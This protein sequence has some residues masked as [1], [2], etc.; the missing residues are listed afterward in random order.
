MV[1]GD[2]LGKRLDLGFYAMR[3]AGFVRTGAGVVTGSGHNTKFVGL[4]MGKINGKE[5]EKR[6][7]AEGVPS[8]TYA[9]CRCR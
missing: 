1:C 3:D 2:H 5:L 8:L 9:T 7:V 4:L 6:C